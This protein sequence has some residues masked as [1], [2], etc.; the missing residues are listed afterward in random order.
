MKSARLI[1]ES[2]PSPLQL[3]ALHSL[4]RFYSRRF[5]GSIT[6]E[7]AERLA[8]AAD[9]LGRPLASFAELTADEAAK[10]IDLMKDALG[11]TITPPKRRGSWQRPDR[12]QARAYGTAGRRGQPS[13]EIRL[14]DLP[15][16][17]LV[18]RLRAQLGWSPARLEGFL[19]SS[20]SPVSGGVIRTLPEANG[21]IW[22]L[23]NMLRR[24]SRNTQISRP[25]QGSLDFGRIGKGR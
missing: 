10:L 19:K 6:V 25:D 15:T 7:R 20:K 5:L 2:H 21:V 17:E 24:A 16:L 3:A 13:K 4:F 14:V 9:R 8:W 1:G 18:D 22:A 11:Q 23:R 12:D